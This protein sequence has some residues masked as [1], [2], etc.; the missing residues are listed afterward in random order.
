VVTGGVL[1]GLGKG[2]VTSSIGKLLQ[3]Q[4]Y[5]VT[6]IKIDPY[7]NIDAGTIRPT[8]H[9][10]VFVTEDGGEIDQ[11]LG[12]Y[13]RFLDINLHKDHNITTGQVYL[14]VITN[15]RAGKY[16]GEDVEVMPHIPEEVKRRIRGTAERTKADFVLIE[17]GGT[18]GD[19]QNILFMEAARQ[20]RLDGDDVVFVH[21]VYLPIPK[22][23]GEMKT[24]PAQ[25]S[26]LKSMSF[27]M[28]PDFVIGRAERALDDPRKKTLSFT[29]NI[30]KD[31]IFSAPDLEFIYEEPLVF[32][33]QGLDKQILKMFNLEYHENGKIK[34][35][36]DFVHRFRELKK[37]VTIGIV[38]KYFD[39]GDFNLEDSYISVIEAIKHAC[40]ELRVKPIIKWINSKQ[41]EKDPSK[42]STLKELGG[43]IVPGGFGESGVE[44][45]ILAIKYARENDIPYLGLC[46]GMQLAVV[47][48]ARDVCGMKDAHTTEISKDTKHPVIDILPEQVKHLKFSDYGATMRLGEY[49]AVLKKDTLIYKLYGTDKVSERHRHRYEVNPEYISKIE[50]KGLVF[51]GSSPD[52]RLMEFME[53]PGHKYF[54]GTQAHPEFKSRPLKP[55]PLFLGLV[56]AASD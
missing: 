2:V 47:E 15:E 18:V 40:F 45:K 5:S 19:Y 53:I 12:N 8:E 43:L 42:V 55:H 4:G 14:Q 37:E 3:M 24:K 28:T 10:E 1:S 32:Y 11:D 9:G 17:I 31:R 51:S 39:T 29:C 41:F 26:I 50:E 6:A 33:D 16:L 54:V 27:G 36:C 7:I 22:H 46:Y 20:M 35:W 13:E 56:K 52:R 44:G 23:I 30:P 21:V 34:E 48:F 49:P 25:H 38:G